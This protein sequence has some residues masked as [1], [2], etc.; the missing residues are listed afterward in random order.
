MQLR[1]GSIAKGN[2]LKQGTNAHAP[3]SSYSSAG[4]CQDDFVIC[5]LR[6][7]RAAFS[8]SPA[9]LLVSGTKPLPSRPKIQLDNQNYNPASKAYGSTFG[10]AVF[11]FSDGLVIQ[12]PRLSYPLGRYH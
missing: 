1:L 12:A 3:Y 4:S 8:A 6:D 5:D 7:L 2:R 10:S 11:V 9:L